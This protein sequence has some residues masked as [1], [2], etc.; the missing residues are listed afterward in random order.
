[1]IFFYCAKNHTKNRKEK[2]QK[3]GENKKKRY[4]QI[5]IF[6]FLSF[7][8]FYAS[9]LCFKNKKKKHKKKTEIKKKMEEL[10]WELI[11]RVGEWPGK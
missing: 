4:T 6:Q 11:N 2:N 9:L 1:M 7:N 8:L 5:L 3:I 10:K